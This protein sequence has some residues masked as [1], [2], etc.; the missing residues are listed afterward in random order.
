[1]KEDGVQRLNNKRAV[2]M[3]GVY[4]SHNK[5]VSVLMCAGELIQVLRGAVVGGGRGRERA[6]VRVAISRVAQPVH[7]SEHLSSCEPSLS[8]AQ[9]R[10]RRKAHLQELPGGTETAQ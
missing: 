3:Y 4:L 5:E 8:T 1:M 7:A 2:Y 9:V 10:R 6:H